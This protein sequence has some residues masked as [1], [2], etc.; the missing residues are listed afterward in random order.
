MREQYGQRQQLAMAAQ[1]VV[2]CVRRLDAGEEIGPS[3]LVGLSLAPSPL[4][5][6]S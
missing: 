5:E 4:I 2:L 1:V 6:L 3:G